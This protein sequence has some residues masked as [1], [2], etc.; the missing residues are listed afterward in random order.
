MKTLRIMVVV[1]MALCIVVLSFLYAMER[2]ASMQLEWKVSTKDWDGQNL[3]EI[4]VEHAEEPTIMLEFSD[5][6][7][8]YSVQRGNAGRLRQIRIA[9][10]YEHEVGVRIKQDDKLSW[11]E[12]AWGPRG[13]RGREN[14]SEDFECDGTYDR[15][16]TVDQTVIRVGDAWYPVMWSND[17]VF[18]VSGGEVFR[19][20][21]TDSGYVRASVESP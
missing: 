8:S 14:R 5:G 21:Q 9:D 4:L 11:L 7:E 2:R 3:A 13:E 17:M 1:G 15:R 6:W 18:A 10:G 19:V 20:V 16:T 12:V